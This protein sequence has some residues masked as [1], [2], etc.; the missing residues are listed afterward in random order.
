MHENDIK[1][2][3]NLAPIPLAFEHFTRERDVNFDTGFSTIALFKTVFNHVTAKAHVMTYWEGQQSHTT[4]LDKPKSY[5]ERINMIL[6]S[7]LSGPNDLPP[8]NRKGPKK[9]LSLEQKFLL[10]MM[11]LHLGLLQED[12]AWRFEVSDTTVSKVVTTWTKLLSKEDHGQ[13][14]C[15]IEKYPKKWLFLKNGDNF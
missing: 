7:P 11:R 9:K 1:E 5:Q 15:D 3:C 8:I 4:T 6:S 10:I 13:K 14:L 2:R 12:L